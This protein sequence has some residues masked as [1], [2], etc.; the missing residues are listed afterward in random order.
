MSKDE[1]YIPVNKDELLE[2]KNLLDEGNIEKARAILENM[3]NRDIRLKDQ[4]FPITI[5]HNDEPIFK[6]IADGINE[7]G[8]GAN[9]KYY[10]KDNPVDLKEIVHKEV[11]IQ[12]ETPDLPIDYLS[13]EVIRIDPPKAQEYNAFFAMKF[14]QL[15][16]AEKAHIKAYIGWE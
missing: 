7:N 4:S 16:K 12:L 5:Y 15:A 10:D 2:C 1:L 8:I 11:K 13:G 9:V 14:T 3:L 6:G